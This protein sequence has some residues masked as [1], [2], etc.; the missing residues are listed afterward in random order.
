MAKQL[1]NVFPG[2]EE[3]MFYSKHDSAYLAKKL[4]ISP[5][6]V[7]RRLNGQVEF[8]LSEITA[9][10]NIYNCSFEELFQKSKKA[11]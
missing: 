7:R 2:L 6:S 8:E 9:L 4:N 3:K 5:C 1:K 10:M 11:S